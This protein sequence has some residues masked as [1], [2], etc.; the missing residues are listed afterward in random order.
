MIDFLLARWTFP[1]FQY[2]ITV[3]PPGIVVGFLAGR[4]AGYCKEKWTLPV[5]YSRKIFHFTIFTLAGIIGSIGGFPAVQVFGSAITLIVIYSVIKGNGDRL[6]PAIARPSDAPYE[7]FYIIVPLLMTALGGMTSNIL[8]GPL[9]IVGY[10]TT[11]WGDAV[12]E[13]VGTRWG[14]HRYRVPTFTGI[15][16]YRSLEGSA[17]VFLASL[18]GCLLFL[19]LGFDLSFLTVFLISVFLAIVTTF[20]EAVTFHSMDNLTIQVITS[21]ACYLIFKQCGF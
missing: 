14:K 7:K 16:A 21:G 17:A 3:F 18:L 9:A 1:G 4:W 10:I 19:G 6:Y 2:W 12:G 8:F 15:K 5:G 13:P 11:G 20:V